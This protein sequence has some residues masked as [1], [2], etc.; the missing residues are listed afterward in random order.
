[1]LK[2]NKKDN[3]ILEFYSF[4]FHSLLFWKKYIDIMKYNIFLLQIR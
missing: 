1:M 4:H 3:T 2:I